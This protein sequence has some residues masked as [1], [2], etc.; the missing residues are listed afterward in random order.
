MTRGKGNPSLVLI[1][2]GNRR[3]SCKLVVI[4][5]KPSNKLLQNESAKEAT[6][7]QR[8]TVIVNIKKNSLISRDKLIII[9]A[10]M[11]NKVKVEE[12]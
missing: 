11:R 7:E 12:V 4:V 6:L 1:V 8:G 3:G 5:I 10:V 9:F 2:E